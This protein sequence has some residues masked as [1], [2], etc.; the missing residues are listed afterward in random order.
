MAILHSWVYV[1]DKRRRLKKLIPLNWR[2]LIPEKAVNHQTR[3]QPCKSRNLAFEELFAYM[4]K[5][6]NGKNAPTTI[7]TRRMHGITTHKRHF[8][9]SPEE[10]LTKDLWGRLSNEKATFTVA[11]HENPWRRQVYKHNC[12]YNGFLLNSLKILGTQARRRVGALVTS[13]TF[14]TSGYL[15]WM[16]H[17]NPS[18]SSYSS[19]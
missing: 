9:Q 17:V 13:S 7:C 12:N 5:T 19:W 10:W 4:N 14:C 6:C 1:N 15:Y 2:V 3:H 11:N 18:H 16:A 8:T